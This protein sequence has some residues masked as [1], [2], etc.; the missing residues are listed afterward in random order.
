MA[1]L[2][3]LDGRL[4]EGGECGDGGGVGSDLRQEVGVAAQV[5]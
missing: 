2:H 4:R 1:D 3:I 5:G